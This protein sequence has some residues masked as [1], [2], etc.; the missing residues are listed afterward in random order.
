ML[1]WK[2]GVQV[3]IKTNNCFT[4]KGKL[5]RVNHSGFCLNC[6][7]KENKYTV[8]RVLSH[9]RRISDPKI[10]HLEYLEAKFNKSKPCPSCGLPAIGKLCWDCY[11]KTKK[12]KPL[13]RCVD[14]GNETHGVRCWGCN[15]LFRRNHKL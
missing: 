5:S 7:S 8:S 3:P 9:K 4:C 2:N 15:L 10:A 12:R 6:I 11:L 14:C 1:V 13:P